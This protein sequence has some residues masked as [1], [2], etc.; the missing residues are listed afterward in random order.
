MFD[1][2]NIRRSNLRI[3]HVKM[4]SKILEYYKSDLKNDK[5]NIFKF[6]ILLL[7]FKL[8]QLVHLPFID[9]KFYTDWAQTHTVPGS[10]LL[11][12]LL[13]LICGYTLGTPNLMCLGLLPFFYL[14]ISGE[15]YIGSIPAMIIL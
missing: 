7:I 11:F 6:I 8:L 15:L 9:V 14:T 4:L 1:E 10:N 13:N 5:S 2:D 3:K 12:E